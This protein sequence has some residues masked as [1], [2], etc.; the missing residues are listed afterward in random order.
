MQFD[1]TAGRLLILVAALWVLAWAM[2]LGVNLH[3]DYIGRLGVAEWSPQADDPRASAA[4]RAA[5]HTNAAFELAIAEKA[6]VWEGAALLL[7]L[8]APAGVAVAVSRP[9][10]ARR[11]RARAPLNVVIA[12]D[13]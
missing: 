3:R 10:A 6:R 8:V 12:K 4:R 13:R 7:G 5:A 1:K 9:W 2:V 11:R